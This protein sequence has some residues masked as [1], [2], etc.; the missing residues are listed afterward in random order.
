M[1][2]DSLLHGVRRIEDQGEDLLAMRTYSG[3]EPARRIDIAMDALLDIAELLRAGAPFPP[4][5]DGHGTGEYR[6]DGGTDT[7]SR[8]DDLVARVLET[9]Y[10]RGGAT[11]ERFDAETAKRVMTGN[12]FE[13]V[14]SWVIVPLGSSPPYSRNWRPV[15]EALLARLEDVLDDFERIGRRIGVAG[16]E[17]AFA[18]GCESVVAMLETLRRIVRRADADARYVR[19][20]T[21]QQ[22][23]ELLSTI[24]TATTQLQS[25]D[26]A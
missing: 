10:E 7:V 24:E 4:R 19:N 13:T 11:I 12:R 5:V 8:E 17:G 21:D 1:R 15:V 3:E 22:Q 2:A 9:S 18:T 14:D 16:V 20:R 23:N 26:N 25:D 6:P